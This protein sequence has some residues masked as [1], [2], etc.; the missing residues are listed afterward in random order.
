MEDK[1][2]YAPLF[3]YDADVFLMS[4]NA[5]TEDGILINIDGNANRVSALAPQAP[6]KSS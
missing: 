2:C 5:M 4:A 6:A 1:R 3:A